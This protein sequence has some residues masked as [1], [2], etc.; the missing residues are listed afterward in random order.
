[1]AKN[2]YHYS[3]PMADM[4]VDV[5]NTVSGQLMVVVST[6]SADYPVCESNVPTLV[7][8]RRMA[9][10]FADGIRKGVIPHPDEHIA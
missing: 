1:M 10:L 6:I 3:F 2:P 7:G 9:R 5:R 4:R 8:A